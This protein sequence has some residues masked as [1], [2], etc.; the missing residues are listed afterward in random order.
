MRLNW[1]FVLSIFFPKWVKLCILKIVTAYFCSDF[2]ICV[3]FLFSMFP[4]SRFFCTFFEKRGEMLRLEV[5][6]L[7]EI[8]NFQ[9]AILA[10]IFITLEQFCYT[11]LKRSFHLLLSDSKLSKI[12]L[13]T[14]L[15]NILEVGVIKAQNVSF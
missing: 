4:L 12:G 13:G 9:V 10:K 11:R 6:F 5:P 1:Y 14:I 2:L 15:I 8:L 3:C 7:Q